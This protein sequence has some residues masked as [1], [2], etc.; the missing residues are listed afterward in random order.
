MT[1]MLFKNFHFLPQGAR[2]IGKFH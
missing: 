2:D 1:Y